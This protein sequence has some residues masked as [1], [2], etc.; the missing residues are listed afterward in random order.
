MG[1]IRLGKIFGIEVRLHFSWV[2]IFFLVGYSLS[3]FYFPSQYKGLPRSSYVL[4]G[5]AATFL[6]F[7]SILFHEMSHSVVARRNGIPIKFITLFVFGG[8]SSIAKEPDTPAIELKMAA[9]GPAASIFLGVMFGLMGAA[10]SALRAGPQVMGVVAYLAVINVLLG[11]FNLVPGF[12]LDGGRLLRA[13]IWK[14]TGNLQRATKIAAD[15]G[16]GI[17]LL[18]IMTGLLGALSGNLVNG[19]WF[20]FIGWF[21]EQAARGS[22]Q[23]VVV[24]QALSRVLV[25]DVMTPEPVTIPGEITLREAADLYFLRYRHTGFPVVAGDEPVGVVSLSDMREA[26]SDE[27]ENVRVDEVMEP[28]G[29]DAVVEAGAHVTDL[30]TRLHDRETDRLLVVDGNH[31]IAGIVTNDDIT[32]YLR[33]QV[34]L[35]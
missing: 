7:A 11:I 1:A 15:M 4:M 23:Q 3:F 8:V 21:L 20:I 34:A 28:L 2:L 31:H 32:R 26:P 14:F 33:I 18:L 27:W 16:R 19:L 6:F 25:R 35:K 12:P 10:A 9:A 13:L 30:L 22:Y 17:A 24:S 29:R 5:L